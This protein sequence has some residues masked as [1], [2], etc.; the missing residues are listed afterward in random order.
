MAESIKYILLIE[1]DLVDQMAIQR[2]L[3]KKDWPIQLITVDAIEDAKKIIQEQHLDL[4]VSDLNLG[5][6][7]AENLLP[8]TPEAIPLVVISG[9]VNSDVFSPALIQ[10][11]KAIHQKD[12]D[13]HYLNEILEHISFLFNQN[14]TP[15]K[16]AQA[17][18]NIP[19]YTQ[20]IYKRLLQIFDQDKSYVL[21]MMEVFLQQNPADL[22]KLNQAIQ[23]NNWTEVGLIAHKIKSGFNLMGLKQQQEHSKAIEQ[24]VKELSPDPK[25]ISSLITKLNNETDTIYQQL[26]YT[27]LAQR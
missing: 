10:K 22:L 12:Q 20:S 3:R 21:D 11:A 2:M 27:L 4:I 23:A 25:K 7:N 6:G 24:A 26:K 17:T 16:S 19:N 5:D 14:A 13:L 8:F 9:E 15:L 18:S 1:D